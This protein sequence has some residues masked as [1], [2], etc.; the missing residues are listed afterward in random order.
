MWHSATSSTGS[1][2]HSQPGSSWHFSVA[3]R[4]LLWLG[5]ILLLLAQC[6]LALST[7][8]FQDFVLISRASAR[9]ADVSPAVTVTD[10]KPS[11]KTMSVA[12]ESKRSD[13]RD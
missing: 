10:T 6:A 3:Q 12:F 11:S 9:Q 13:R 2:R 4:Q 1:G 8:S 5:V 7:P